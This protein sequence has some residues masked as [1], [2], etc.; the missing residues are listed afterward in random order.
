MA[1]AS[2]FVTVRLLAFCDNMHPATKYSFIFSG[3]ENMNFLDE[4]S[5]CEYIANQVFE[6]TNTYSGALWDT[7][8]AGRLP[9][10]RSHTALSTG[11]E[12]VID[13]AVVRCT[14]FG[15]DVITAAQVN[16]TTTVLT[17]LIDTLVPTRPSKTVPESE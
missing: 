1:Q 5:R 12:L 2:A 8:I 3:L 10:P 9:S 7:K 16:D 13:G 17:T 4:E 15:W 6:A 11:D 14:S